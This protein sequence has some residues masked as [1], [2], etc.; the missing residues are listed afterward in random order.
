MAGGLLFFQCSGRW[1]AT[2]ESQESTVDCGLATSSSTPPHCFLNYGK[3]INSNER[4]CVCV[5]CNFHFFLR[6]GN[7]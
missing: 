7:L 6:F 3:S 4:V 1:A 2:V 5:A